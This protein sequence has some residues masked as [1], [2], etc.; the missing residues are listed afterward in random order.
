MS[1]C[2]SFHECHVKSGR[3]N[4]CDWFSK[5]CCVFPHPD[6]ENFSEEIDFAED[7]EDVEFSECF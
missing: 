2:P 5:G 6:L 1:Q 4:Y 7:A 3:D